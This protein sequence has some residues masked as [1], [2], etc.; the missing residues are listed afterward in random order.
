MN[1]E[2]LLEK[3]VKVLD[4][5]KQ[6]SPLIHSITNYVT[7]NDCANTILALGALAIMT[8]DKN[9]VYEITKKSKSLV[10]N[11]GT[12]SENKLESMLISSKLANELNIPVILDPVGVGGTTF[13]NEAVKRLLNEAHFNIIRGN[14][15][16]I[17]FIDGEKP[18]AVGVDSLVLLDTKDTI[19]IAKNVVNKYN[20][21]TV[22][23]GVNDI[24]A[25]DKNIAIIKNGHKNMKK[26]TGA[27]CM[28]SAAIGA[29][30]G[31]S[32]DDFVSAFTAMLLMGVAANIAGESN[33][34]QG[35]YTFRNSLM[36]NI[37]LIDHEKLIKYA[38]FD[39]LNS[40][41]I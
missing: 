41:L 40:D 21:T 34:K 20:C 35:I 22:I 16:E 15:S 4:K 31:A 14:I 9:E 27:G 36:D 12:L 17:A 24:L 33:N 7:A 2:L 3:A 25:D 10:I 19:K 28:S 32:S 11:T 6:K 13:R 26:I 30:A 18:T 23:T 5:I 8:D 37:S 29:C 39:L 38:E 1:K